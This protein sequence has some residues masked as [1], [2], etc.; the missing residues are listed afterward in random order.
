[1]T[2][3]R[4]RIQLS[5]RFFAAAVLICAALAFEGKR[6]YETLPGPDVPF[7]TDP[8]LSAAMHEAF[9][10]PP[11]DYNAAMP[12]W[13]HCTPTQAMKDITAFGDE[14]I[15]VLVAN[16]NNRDVWMR[17]QTYLMLSMIDAKSAV[18]DLIRAL[19]NSK[20][21]DSALLIATL[22]EITEHPDGYGYYRWYHDERKAEAIEM[23][24]E[25]NSSHSR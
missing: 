15:P 25:W 4:T 10:N 24:R 19:E 22:T 9:E 11:D 17:R 6:Y 14:A 8:K 12:G 23:F 5:L 2:R 20:R 7:G 1:M 3:R 18:P 16:L 13:P 21:P